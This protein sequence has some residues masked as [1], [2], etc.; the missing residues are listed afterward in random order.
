MAKINE[1]LVKKEN[2]DKQSLSQWLDSMKPQIERALP[3]HLK[4]DRFLRVVLTTLRMNSKLAA[5]EPQS[6]LAA[7][8]T[9]AQLGLEINT[10]LGEAYIIP[11]KTEA[12]FQLGYRGILALAY[13]TN[14]YRM[15]Y[16]MEVYRNDQF[17]YEYGLNPDL[18]H[19]PAP[20]PEGDPTHYYAVY[21]LTNGGMAFRVWARDKVIAHAEKFSQSYKKQTDSPWKSDFDSMAKKTVLIDLFKYAPKS[22]EFAKALTFDET[23]R[24]SVSEDMDL[25]PVID[26]DVDVPA[27]EEKVSEVVDVPGDAVIDAEFEDEGEGLSEKEMAALEAEIGQDSLFDDA[28]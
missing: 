12:S 10:P 16:A 3:S 8:M 1:G 24:K 25:E 5:C 9:S 20:K 28:K 17:S 18:V 26:V 19:K 11:Y 2:G 7:M 23:I 15:V 21:H 27:T 4:A 22:V 6:F 13:R 14:M